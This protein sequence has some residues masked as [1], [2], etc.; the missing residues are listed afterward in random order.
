MRIDQ[1]GKVIQV[2]KMDETISE[3]GSERRW[4]NYEMGGEDGWFKDPIL[5]VI[6]TVA[7]ILSL[8][9]AALVLMVLYAPA[10]QAHSQAEIEAQDELAVTRVTDALRESRFQITPEL[11]AEVEQIMA[12]HF[13]FVD[14]HRCHYFGDCPVAKPTANRRVASP[15]GAEAWR[16]LI[17]AYFPAGVVDNFVCLVWYESRGDPNAVNPSSGATGLLQIM[18]F[19]HERWPGNYYDP[20]WNVT[21]ARRIYDIQGL[22]AW[23]PYNRGLCR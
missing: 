22:R 19:W 13:E 5:Y 4:Y 21:I 8:L 14:R 12:D 1:P 23:A 18:P 3:S 17:A 2:W 6:A 11:L 15:A 20:N 16:S 10:A 9:F 7:T